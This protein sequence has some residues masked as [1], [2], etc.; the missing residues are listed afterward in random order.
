MIRAAVG[1]TFVQLSNRV[2]RLEAR[3]GGDL[4]A[5]KMDLS[6]LQKDVEQAVHCAIRFYC[7]QTS[8]GG[9]E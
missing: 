8:G 7:R 6:K 1:D 2:S 5:V 4:T 9:T 3:K